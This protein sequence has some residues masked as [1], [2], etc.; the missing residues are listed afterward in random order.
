[1]VLKYGKAALHRVWSETRA[2]FASLH[3]SPPDLFKVLILKV[4]SRCLPHIGPAFLSGL[5]QS[6]MSTGS[7]CCPSYHVH[8]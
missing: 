8:A 4:R 2:G 1:M 7:H 3:G 6:L 5:L